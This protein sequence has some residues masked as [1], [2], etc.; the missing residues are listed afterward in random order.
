MYSI[1]GR[2]CIRRN[3]SSVLAMVGA[4]FASA[5]SSSQLP[6]FRK[7]YFFNNSVLRDQSG[8]QG[9]RPKFGDNV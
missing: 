1:L 9:G 7:M 6:L 4:L 8:G 3:V 5:L 2:T